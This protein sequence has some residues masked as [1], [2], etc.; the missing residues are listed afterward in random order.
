MERKVRGAL[1]LVL[2]TAFA[3]AGSLHAQVPPLVEAELV[4]MGRVVDPGCTGKLYRPLF[5]KNDYNTYWP[6][7]AAAPNKSLKLY[8]GVT[9]MRD[10]SYG[11]QPKDLMDIFVPEKAGANRTV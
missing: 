8:P 5:G 10:V 7:D 9:V 2:L 1:G 6:V 4:K 3:S 11:P